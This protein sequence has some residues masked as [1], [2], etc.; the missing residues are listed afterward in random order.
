MIS[1]QLIF[2]VFICIIVLYYNILAGV[3]LSDYLRIKNI[4][5]IK[6]K[7]NTNEY[8]NI[9]VA[10]LENNKVCNIDIKNEILIKEIINNI[11]I[12]KTTYYTVIQDKNFLICSKPDALIEIIIIRLIFYYS[13]IMTSIFTMIILIII[14]FNLYSTSIQLTQNEITIQQL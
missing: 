11:D 2:L 10:K 1:Y 6:S 3:Y 12:Y 5:I 13:V 9:F 14:Y 7:D 4:E 8:K